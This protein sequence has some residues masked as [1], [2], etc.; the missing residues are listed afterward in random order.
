MR[1]LLG[2]LVVGGLAMGGSVASAAP[3]NVE[4]KVRVDLG[5]LGG[6]TIT[7]V[8]D[9]ELTG[10]GSINLGGVTGSQLAVPAGLV[11]LASQF[12]I[13]LTP[14]QSTLVTNIVL[15]P[16]LGNAAG[17]FQTGFMP[18]ANEQCPVATGQACVVG[19]GAGGIMTIQGTVTATLA[20]GIMAP[21]PLGQLGIGAGGG[22]VVGLIAGEGAPFT[23]GV[24]QAQ[25]TAT[26]NGPP[27]STMGTN[28][29]LT[30]VSPV[31]VS[32]LGAALPIFV[33]F[34]IIPTPEPGWVSMF[35][36]G[37]V[38]LVIASRLRR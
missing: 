9:V 18:T 15:N 31:F 23:T 20:G 35:G 21:V 22:A 10:T 36:A 4:A 37:I 11:T 29:P 12:S 7:G 33:Q 17:S 19:G 27:V 13:P 32:A 5:A 28:D 16:G 3:V 26:A 6:F 24:G 34:E 8:G 25:T 38:G 2:L 1:K 30:F 14:N